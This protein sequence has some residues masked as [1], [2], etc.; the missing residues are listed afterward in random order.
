MDRRW[1]R[2]PARPW[3]QAGRPPRPPRACETP[4]GPRRPP[5]PAAAPRRAGVVL[6]VQAA[7]PGAVELEVD[8]DGSSATAIAYPSLVGEVRVGDRVLLNTTAVDL[9]L[10]TGGAHF[11]IA[12]DPIRDESFHRRGGLMK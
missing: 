7:R 12:A 9:G 10:G 6:A 11:V 3:P 1:G 5:R 2:R 4:G 8:V